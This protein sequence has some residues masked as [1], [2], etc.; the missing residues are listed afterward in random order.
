[1][2]TLFTR[3]TKHKLYVEMAKNY[4]AVLEIIRHG[5]EVVVEHNHS[6]W[7]FVGPSRDKLSEVL[8]ILGTP[9]LGLILTACRSNPVSYSLLSW[10]TNSVSEL[11]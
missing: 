1:M 3:L 11:Q 8:R 9:C 6:H 5:A 2:I 4:A 10:P 7:R